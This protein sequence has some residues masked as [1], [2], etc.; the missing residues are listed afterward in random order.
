MHGE[1][2]TNKIVNDSF[3]ILESLGFRVK[4]KVKG[5]LCVKSSKAK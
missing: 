1:T 4:L 3:E 5:V 2:A